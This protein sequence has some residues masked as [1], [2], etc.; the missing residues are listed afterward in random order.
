MY[1]DEQTAVTLNNGVAMPRIGLGVWKAEDGDEVERAVQSAI[2]TGYR[3]IDTAAIY[4][5]EAGVGSGIRASGVPREELFVTT[6]LWN[7]DQGAK[8][9]QSAFDESLEK[10]GLDY[11]DLYLIHW[12]MPEVGKIVETWKEFEK[13]LADGKTRAIGVSNFRIEDLEELKKHSAITPAV[14]QIELHPRL[15]QR[16]LR[17]YCDENGIFVES[18]SPIGG[19]KGD[20]LS[21]E[22]LI[23]IGKRYGKSPAQVVIRWHLQNNLIVIPKSVQPQRIKQNFDVFDFELSSDDMNTIAQLENGQRQGPDPATM[24]VY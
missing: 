10:I 15:P 11:V 13:L 21:D 14:N 1:Y 18:W 9:V 3:L 12:P 8:N 20:L 17:D 19:S 6:K 23:E 4:K 2:E 22:S 5:N 16:E 7:S 24:N